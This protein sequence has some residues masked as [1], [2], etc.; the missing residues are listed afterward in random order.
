VALSNLQR[1]GLVRESSGRQ[2]GRLFVYQR[3]LD[4][5]NEGTTPEEPHLSH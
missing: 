1:L 3:Y 5:L 2:R 4:R